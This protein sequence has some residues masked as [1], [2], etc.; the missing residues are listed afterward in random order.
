MLNISKVSKLDGIRSWSLQAGDTCPGAFNRDGSFVDA[1]AGCYARG[2][3]Y[4][5]ENVKK[6]RRENLQDWKTDDWEDR[7]VAALERETYFR[8]FD[9]GDM[10]SLSLAKKIYNVMLRAWWVDFWLPT[11]MYKFAKFQA[12]IDK[13]NTLPNAKVRFSSDSILGE[14]VKGLHGSTIIASYDDVP[15]GVKVCEAYQHEG[16][17]NGCRSCWDKNVDVIAYPVHGAT[18]KKNVRIKLAQVA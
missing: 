2:G 8:W 6:P 4:H 11:R 15:A 16:K 18:A 13:M 5:G 9:S 1:C 17:C 14:F 7:M 12:I 3:R 10:Y